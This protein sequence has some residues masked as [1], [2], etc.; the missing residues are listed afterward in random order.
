MQNLLTSW[1]QRSY[2]ALFFLLPW[3]VEVFPGNFGIQVPAEPLMLV[4]SL[5]LF[6][7]M[8]GNQ[9]NKWAILQHFWVILFPQKNTMVRLWCNPLALS[10]LWLIWMGIAAVFS[11][12]PLVSWKYWAVETLHWWLFAFGMALVPGLWRKALPWL[13]LSM[14]LFVGYTLSH[15]SLYGFRDD[16]A[17]LSPMPFFPEHTMY[18]AV[19]ALLL[20]WSTVM[21]HRFGANQAQAPLSGWKNL[22]ASYGPSSLLVSIYAAGLWFASC[23]A[24]WLSLAAASVVLLCL[25]CF[26]AWGNFFETHSPHRTHKLLCRYCSRTLDRRLARMLIMGVSAGLF[27]GPLLIPPMA[28]NFAIQDVSTLERL[29]RYAC[30]RQMVRERPLTGFGPGTFQFQYLPF[31]RPEHTTRIS[32]T[33]PILARNADTFGRGGGAH[34][35]YLQSLAETG[36]PGLVLQWSFLST[37]LFGLTERYQKKQKWAVLICL[38]SLL[39]FLL[40]GMVNNFLHD[41]R[42]A[43]LVWG[44][45]GYYSNLAA[46]RNTL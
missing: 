33:Q 28:A 35:E 26:R 36:W 25:F 30:A 37:I 3:S 45:I 5:L 16:Q 12:M 14:A 43:A 27:L 20:P 11:S 46:H 2:A 21:A 42:V 23:R 29:N 19:L 31:Q 34:S 24:A 22:I 17:L 9:A 18:A 41:G 32:I 38:C 6:G 15:H 1:L 44:A 10:F 8:V 39:T 40:H 13:G 7:Y 4:C